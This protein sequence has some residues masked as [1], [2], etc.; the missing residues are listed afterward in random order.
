MKTIQEKHD[1]EI[2]DENKKGK[3]F[4]MIEENQSDCVYHLGYLGEE[5]HQQI[6]DAC[7]VCAKIIECMRQK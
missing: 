1:F 3:D 6:P 2:E 7:L 4:S 5:K